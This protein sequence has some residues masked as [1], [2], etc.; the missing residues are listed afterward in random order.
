MIV[1]SYCA[2]SDMGEGDRIGSRCVVDSSG[3]SLVARER[4]IAIVDDYLASCLGNYD[5]KCGSLAVIATKVP[6]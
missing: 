5:Q 6:E 3:R 4:A 2:R 1:R